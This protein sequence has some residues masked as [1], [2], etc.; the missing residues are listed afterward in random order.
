MTHNV[1]G[2]QVPFDGWRR[3]INDNAPT[4]Y[5]FHL[6]GTENTAA[7]RQILFPFFKNI[8]SACAIGDGEA[9]KDSP[10]RLTTLKGHYTSSSPSINDCGGYHVGFIR[11]AAAYG[12]ILP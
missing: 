2:D 4:T 9:F 1:R 6:G 8:G 3:S 7:A 12:D 10:L 5:P 11:F